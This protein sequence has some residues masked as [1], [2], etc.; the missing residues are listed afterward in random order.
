[1][2]GWLENGLRRFYKRLTGWL[3]EE[4]LRLHGEELE[5]AGEEWGRGASLPVLARMGWDALWRLPFEYWAE[6]RRDARYGLR[7]MARSPALTL[8]AV[9][10]LGVGLSVATTVFLEL[11]SVVFRQVPGVQEPSRLVRLM[12]PLSFPDYEHLRDSSGVFESFSAYLAPVPVAVKTGADER[13]VRLWAHIVTPDYFATLGARPSLG[14]LFD[15][16]GGAEAVLS[17]RLWQTRFAGDP[18]IVGRPIRINGQAARVMGV[19]EEGFLGASPMLAAADVFLPVTVPAAVAP[20]V[21]GDRLLQRRHA[22]FTTVGRLKPGVTVERAEAVLDGL[23]RQIEQTYQDEDRDRIGRRVTLL[24]GGRMFPVRDRDLP[25]VTAFPLILVSLILLIACSSVATMLL[26]RASQRA[27][28]V[29]VRLAMGAS[30]GRLV[31]QL[32][33]ESVMLAVLGAVA[34]L[35]LTYWSI[36][37]FDSLRPMLPGYVSID[38]RF[39]ALAYLFTLGVTVLTGIAFGLAPALQAGKAD[40]ASSLKAGATLLL[41]R[42]GAVS[43]RNLLV[44]H[45]VASSLAVLFLTGMIVVGFQRKANPDLGYDQRGL[46]VASIDPVRDGYSAAESREYVEALLQR[47]RR[48]PGVLGAAVMAQSPLLGQGG[49]GMMETKLDFAQGAQD[50]RRVRTA[51]V[52][53]GYFDTLGLAPLRGRTFVEQDTTQRRAVVVVNEEMAA[54]AWPGQNPLGQIF[55]SEG[56][57]YQ[58]VGVVKNTRSQFVFEP[59]HP[60]VYFPVTPEAYGEPRAFGLG[61][62]MRTTQGVD[63]IPAVQETAAALAPELTVFNTASVAQRMNEMLYMVKVS[64]LVYGILGVFSLILGVV[65]LGGVTAYAVARRT[66]EIGIRVALGARP[67]QVMRLVLKEGVALVLVGTAIGLAGAYGLALVLRAFLDA[68]AEVTETTMGDPLLVVGAPALLAGL[69]LLACYLPALRS[70][71]I[72]PTTALRE[73]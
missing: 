14:T 40:V 34:G 62:L 61:L 50:L 41:K 42:Y 49:E 12:E 72:S 59:L 63:P 10:S 64:V 6:M 54:K 71:R 60:M 27:K 32:L 24:P 17:H 16:E 5:R 66:K 13:A 46:W 56:R 21:G 55:E 53:A 26:A 52:G 3:P 20:E 73:E 11:E 2:R 35:G 45:Q 7:M 44:L 51:R 36:R 58:V 33:T 29:A 4:F 30:R 37:S 39:G 65:G 47:M 8:A 15:D 57:K 68:M 23:V 9:V 38:F 70:L 25:L 69:A 31:R 22:A 67:R 19:M 1:M 28:E 18:G 43:L 48:T